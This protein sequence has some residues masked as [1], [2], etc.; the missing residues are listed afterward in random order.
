MYTSPDDL[1]I[2]FLELRLQETQTI[3]RHFQSATAIATSRLSCLYSVPCSEFDP[4][5][6]DFF[7]KCVYKNK[8]HIN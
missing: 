7:E 8:N 4:K 6:N 1:N 3:I 2:I 5:S